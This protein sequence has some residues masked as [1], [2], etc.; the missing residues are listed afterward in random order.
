MSDS[1]SKA[2]AV[3]GHVKALRLLGRPTTSV[4][5]I[6]RALGLTDADVETA[7]HDYDIVGCAPDARGRRVSTVRTVSGWSPVLTL[8]PMRGA[9]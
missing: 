1:K 3:N 5:D 8:R 9:S 4:A 2:A 7:L 6:A